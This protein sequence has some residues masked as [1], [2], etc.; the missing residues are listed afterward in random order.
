MAVTMSAIM[1]VQKRQRVE[2]AK[3]DLNQES[4]EFVEQIVR[5]LHGSGYPSASM[6]TT[7]PATPAVNSNQV[8]AGLVDGQTTSIQFEGDMDH[9]GNVEVVRYQLISDPTN[10]VAGRCPCILQ[11]AQI[12]KVN[13]IAP[14][15]QVFAVADFTTE[16]DGIINSSGALP[17]VIDGSFKATDNVTV[18]LND[19]YYASYKI[20]PIFRYFDINGLELT[21]SGA[22]T[23]TDPSGTAKATTD[24]RAVRINV[25]TMSKVVDPITRTFPVNQQK[26]TARISN[27]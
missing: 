2:E 23:F 6:Y 4:R 8:A 19:T 1:D 13:N 12:P 5:D 16:V 14:T 9:D 22:G 3:V 7:P 21:P 15:A 10:V 17:K 18:V 11:R 24:V 27:R 26:S 25:N 20:D